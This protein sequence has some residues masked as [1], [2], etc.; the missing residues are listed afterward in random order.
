[1]RSRGRFAIAAVSA[2]LLLVGVVGCIIFMEPKAQE[3]FVVLAEDTVQVSHSVASRI[4]SVS[5]GGRTIVFGGQSPDDLGYTIGMILAIPPSRE[6]PYGLLRR[7]VDVEQ[8]ADRTTITTAFATLEEAV[9]ACHIDYVLSSA[10]QVSVS[11]S[12]DPKAEITQPLQATVPID[13]TLYEDPDNEESTIKLVGEVTVTIT[14]HF[15]IDIGWEGIEVVG[16]E[17]SIDQDAQVQVIGNLTYEDSYEHE[18]PA[19][20]L[21]VYVIP[22]APFITLAPELNT[23]VGLDA[24]GELTFSFGASEDCSYTAGVEYAHG[25][26]YTI[27]SQQDPSIHPIGPEVEAACSLYAYVKP[28]LLIKVCSVVGPFVNTEAYAE[29]MASIGLHEDLCWKLFAGLG[30]RAGLEIEI[31]GHS[32]ARY[33]T[34]ELAGIHELLAQAEVCDPDDGLPILS[35]VCGT[36]DEAGNVS[37]AWSATD[38]RTPSS[39][40]EYR[41]RLD[42]T[43]PIWSDWSTR[44]AASYIGLQGGEYEFCVLARDDSGNVSAIECCSF[45]IGEDECEGDTDPPVVSLQCGTPTATGDVVFTWSGYDLC[46]PPITYQYKLDGVDPVWSAWTGETAKTYSSL[47]PGLY[48]FCVRARDAVGNTTAISECCSVSVGGDPCDNDQTP[49]TLTLNCSAPSEN[50]DVMFTWHAID[51]CS[52][53]AELEYRHRLLGYEDWSNWGNLLSAQYYG[54]NEGDYTFCVQAR[55][56]HANQSEEC[57]TITVGGSE[58]EE[59]HNVPEWWTDKE[60]YCIGDTITFYFHVT[61]PS[62]VTLKHANPGKGIVDVYVDQLF[63][64]AVHEYKMIAEGPPD[65]QRFQIWVEACGIT[66]YG[67]YAIQVKGCSSP[68]GP[69]TLCGMVDSIQRGVQSPHGI[70]G[71]EYGIT[72]DPDAGIIGR[73]YMSV[74]DTGAVVYCA[75]GAAD[76]DPTISV[77]D[78]VAVGGT[79]IDGVV[80]VDCAPD[81]IVRVQ[82]CE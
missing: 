58:P 3:Q 23:T 82:D 55:D 75:H 71:D 36:P 76:V 74:Y 27:W 48:R 68:Q 32:L 5:D 25:S 45:S 69:H 1:M 78:K 39:D 33:E 13:V 18:L 35:L 46:S 29:L 4:S 41:Y 73:W 24:T 66:R 20:P 10:D 79:S 7:I 37:F 2:L 30:V 44:Q 11:R 51:D 67:N 60:E 14:L 70:V 22:S 8:G 56:A 40:T 59:C 28:E 77:G 12:A 63:Q 57:C 53:P 64:P 42:P 61:A 15:W 38:N 52:Q 50:G 26:Y 9:D 62:I 80:Y 34:D 21:G 81:Y 72:N 54:L 65:T 47:A 6:T 16:F 43:D 49:P 19:I 31:L 17:T